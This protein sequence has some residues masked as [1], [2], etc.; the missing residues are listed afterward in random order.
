M[1]VVN[2]LEAV[3]CIRRGFEK[4]DSGKIAT[5]ASLPLLDTTVSFTLPLWM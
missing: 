5:T 1:P 4:L 3:A 2:G